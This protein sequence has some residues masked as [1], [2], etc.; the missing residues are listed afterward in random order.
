MNVLAATF[1]PNHGALIHCQSGVTWL[2]RWIAEF[3]VILDTKHIACGCSVYLTSVTFL[4]PRRAL[5]RKMGSAASTISLLVNITS[6]SSLL[7]RAP[8]SLHAAP[9]LWSSIQTCTLESSSS[10]TQSEIHRQTDYSV[11]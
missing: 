3:M 1:E 6:A 2:Q 11:S 8:A 5:L 9:H 7:D 10:I 4:T